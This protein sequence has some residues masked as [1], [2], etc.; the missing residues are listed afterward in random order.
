MSRSNHNYYN[1]CHRWGEIG[2][3]G[4][5]DFHRPFG[6]WR[7]YNLCIPAA[8]YLTRRGV[9]RRR[10]RFS[11]WSPKSWHHAPP[12]WWWRV[13]HRRARAIQRREMLRHP[14]DPVITPDRKLIDLW[15]WY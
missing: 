1:L 10:P 15:S 2:E 4:Y 11:V 12:A 7:H 9:V 5:C 3:D 13:Q 8:D 6:P 14:E